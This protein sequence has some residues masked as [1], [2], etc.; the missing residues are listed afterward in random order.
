MDTS[1]TRKGKKHAEI[2][3]SFKS[4]LKYYVSGISFKCLSP[5]NK[6]VLPSD[7]RVHKGTCGY[8]DRVSLYSVCLC[9][10]SLAVSGLQ[11]ICL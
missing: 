7:I 3:D 10:H 1:N 11:M 5:H 4:L 6:S 8:N 9:E 2:T